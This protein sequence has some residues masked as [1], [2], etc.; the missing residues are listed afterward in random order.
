MA[1]TFRDYNTTTKDK[2]AETYYLN[3]LHQSLDFV[4]RKKEEHLQF[5]KGKMTIWQAMDLLTTLVDESDPDTDVPQHIHAFQTAESLRRIYPNYDW[6][7]LVG[8]IHDLGKI[9]SHPLF[10]NEPQW[11]VVGDTFPV[12]CSFSPEIIY[13]DYF[14]NNPDILHPIYSTR[15]GIYQPNIGLDNIEMSWGH[16]EYMYQVCRHNGCSIPEFGLAIIRYHSF[17]PW[18]NKGAYTHLMNSHDYV[19]LEWVRNFQAHDLYTK[20]SIPPGDVEELKKYYQ[21]L[22]DKYFPNEVLEW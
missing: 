20:K 4:K 8:L 12:G 15:Y 16:D 2:V 22:I 18:H 9:L 5:N 19:K 6:L 13:Y 10:G 17:Y 14:K 21:G 7:H 3:H 1:T 11:S